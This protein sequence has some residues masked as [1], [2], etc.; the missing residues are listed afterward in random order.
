MAGFRFSN[1]AGNRRW[2]RAIDGVV[3]LE[4]SVAGSLS[5]SSDAFMGSGHL[6]EIYGD[7]GTLVLHNRTSDYVT[8]FRL[9]VG[10]RA[11]GALTRV[12]DEDAEDAQV[13]GRLGP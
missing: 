13:D 7:E 2:G 1:R 5:V 3:R 11:S 9:N 10:T 8:G 4:N 12:S 6:V